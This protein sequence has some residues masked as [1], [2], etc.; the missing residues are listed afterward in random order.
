MLAQTLYCERII[1]EILITHL[2]DLG[3]KPS[4]RIKL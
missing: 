4:Y 3:L 1:V 2:K